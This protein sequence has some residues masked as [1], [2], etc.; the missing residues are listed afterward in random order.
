MKRIRLFLGILILMGI[1]LGSVISVKADL[2]PPDPDPPLSVWGLVN[3]PVLKKIIPNPDTDGSIYIEWD[4]TPNAVSYEVYRNNIDEGRTWELVIQN[5]RAYTSF[6]D[7]IKIDGRY[8]YK[9]IAIGSKNQI[10]DDSNLEYVQVAIIVKPD[11][12]VDDQ[13]DDQPTPPEQPFMNQFS[14]II[15]IVGI[16]IAITLTIVIIQSN[17]K[18]QISIPR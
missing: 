1:S 16:G 6:T 14:W 13:V 15:V 8:Q 18:K 7:D 10:S 9:V 4:A 12:Q 17:R 2:F 11:D 3:R 5:T